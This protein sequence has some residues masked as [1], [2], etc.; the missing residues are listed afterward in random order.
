MKLKGVI[1]YTWD[2][3]QKQVQA[4]A[5][6]HE[7]GRMTQSGGESSGQSPELRDIPVS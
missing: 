5:T 4:L 1:F 6:F 7:K 2:W 3:L